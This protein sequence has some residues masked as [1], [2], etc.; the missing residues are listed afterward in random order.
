MLLCRAMKAVNGRSGWQ[1]LAHFY[2]DHSPV[3]TAGNGGKA[4]Q[5]CSSVRSSHFD[6]DVWSGRAVTHCV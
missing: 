3:T 1:L 6:P 4:D 2:R 5:I